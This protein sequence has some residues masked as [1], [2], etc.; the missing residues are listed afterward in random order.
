MRAVIDLEG[1]GLLD[2][3][4]KLWCA[5]AFDI[6]TKKHHEFILKDG[7]YD[8]F[9]NFLDGVDTFIGHNIIHYDLNALKLIMGY[10]Y[11]N[12]IIDTLVYSR[13]A[14]PDRKL[15]DGCP[16]H[17]YDPA[18]G[19]KKL[20]G[21]HGL[22]AWGYRVAQHKPY[23]ERWDQWTPDILDRCRDDVDINYKTLLVLKDEMSLPE[24]VSI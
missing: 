2:T 23:I 7:N 9:K 18:L 15:P 1:N 3:L 17:V 6:D 11:S 21:P 24:L 8:E 19:K 12:R 5:V 16:T 20:V 13:T 22:E 4:T 14:N 10:R